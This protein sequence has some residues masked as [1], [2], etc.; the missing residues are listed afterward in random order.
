M[1]IKQEIIYISEATWMACPIGHVSLLVVH[2]RRISQKWN[3]C[4]GGRG[5]DNLDLERALEIMFT[6]TNIYI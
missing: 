6:T 2:F 3:Q 1:E 4:L 5:L